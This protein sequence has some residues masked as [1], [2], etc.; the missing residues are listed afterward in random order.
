V[1]NCAAAEAPGDVSPTPNT[2]DSTCAKIPTDI[3]GSGDQQGDAD[4]Y[5][6]LAFVAANWPVDATTCTAN[7]SSSILTSP[8]D[9]VWLSYLTNDEIFVASGL[10]TGWCHTPTAAG[11]RFASAEEARTAHGPVQFAKLPP[12]GAGPG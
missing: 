8:P 3:L 12:K 5:S 4:L 2:I 1:V 11:A 9:P 10:P 7:A 6:W